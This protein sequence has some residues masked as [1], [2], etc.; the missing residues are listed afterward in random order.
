M[1]TKLRNKLI[2]S[3]INK[4]LLARHLI[5]N[6][7]NCTKFKVSRNMCEKM[8]SKDKYTQDKHESI[9]LENIK[10]LYAEETYEK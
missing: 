6:Q 5:Q 4:T 3:T 2:T 9:V 7:G 10:N 1:K 8:K